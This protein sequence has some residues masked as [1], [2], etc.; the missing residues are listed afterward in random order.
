MFSFLSPDLEPM[1]D[2]EISI[3]QMDRSEFVTRLFGRVT[4]CKE[5]SLCFSPGWEI[6]PKYGEWRKT[7]FGDFVEINAEI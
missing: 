6:I 5:V 3:F 4:H 7:P 2:A 1:P